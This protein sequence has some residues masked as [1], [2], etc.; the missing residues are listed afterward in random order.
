[1]LAYPT[2]GE[3][4]GIPSLE[5]MACKTPVVATNF[6]P[7]KELHDNGRG[8]LFKVLDMVPGEPGC[9]TNFALPDWRD[10]SRK[11]Y[12]VYLNPGEA[13][14]V[15]EEAYAF[16]QKHPWSDKAAQLD[17]IITDTIAARTEQQQAA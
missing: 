11:L 1:V 8:Y 2:R 7:Q 14:K 12:H 6:G 9:L 3:G 5:A 16:A 10:L 17:S 4:F 15:A 13:A